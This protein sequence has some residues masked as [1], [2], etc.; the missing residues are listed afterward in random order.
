MKPQHINKPFKTKIFLQTI[1]S[2]FCLLI[3]ASGFSADKEIVVRQQY[4]VAM[5]SEADCTSPMSLKIMAERGKIFKHKKKKLQAGIVRFIV[6]ALKQKCPELSAANIFGYVNGQLVYQG[7]IAVDDGWKLKT[8]DF[9]ESKAPNPTTHSI[10]TEQRTDVANTPVNDARPL[11]KKQKRKADRK[12][13]KDRKAAKKAKKKEKADEK[14]R[15]YA[16]KLEGRYKKQVEAANYSPALEFKGDPWRFQMK[17]SREIYFGF[18]FL[19]LNGE[20]SASVMK[21]YA[22]SSYN[23]YGSL[24]MTHTYESSSRNIE[25]KSQDYIGDKFSRNLPL[26]DIHATLSLDGEYMSGSAN[27]ASNCTEFQAWKTKF[28]TRVVDDGL[29]PNFLGRSQPDMEQCETFYEWYNASEVLITPAGR[30]SSSAVDYQLA[31]DK[32][33]IAYDGFTVENSNAFRN[34]YQKCG[35]I[36]SNSANTKHAELLKAMSLMGSMSADDAPYIFQ[37]TIKNIKWYR[38]MYF[39]TSIRDARKLLPKMAEEL[40]A[41]PVNL[42]SLKK[43]QADIGETD[44]KGGLFTTLPESDRQKYLSELA[45]V[46]KV[47]AYGVTDE[48]LATVNWDSFSASKEGILKL[49]TTNK[50]IKLSYGGIMPSFGLSRIDR[51]FDKVSL[52]LSRELTDKLID[53]YQTV[54]HSLNGLREYQ[55]AIRRVNKEYSAVLT[56]KHHKELLNQHM[57]PRLTKAR[58]ASVSKMAGWLDQQIPSNRA[59]LAELDK[60]AMDFYGRDIDGLKKPSEAAKVSTGGFAPLLIVKS[61]QIKRSECILPSGFEDMAKA[62]C[63]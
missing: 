35:R 4:S 47:V 29:I 62:F 6:P 14:A 44:A 17:C 56:P 41:L 26:T 32:L 7:E 3:T 49:K 36:L 22:R 61:R 19:D 16:L 34:L 21:G 54:D 33:G 37:N 24:R 59:G 9:S 12:A 38:N 5:D 48:S 57:N 58:T 30:V 42:E 52:K 45:E 23:K 8:V 2:A 10:A 13:K 40:N 31:I 60:I 43:I 20:N 39:A 53:K 15:A 63:L 55:V 11:T 51:E 18:L 46:Q 28:E 25:L 1:L 50:N 27:S